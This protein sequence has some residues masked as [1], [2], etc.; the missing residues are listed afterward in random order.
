MF[1]RVWSRSA[2]RCWADVGLGGRQAFPRAPGS[3]RYNHTRWFQWHADTGSAATQADLTCRNA[4]AV[5]YLSMYPYR[6][7]G[8]CLV[9]TLRHM[10]T[11]PICIVSRSALAR[12]TSAAER[13]TLSSAWY[14]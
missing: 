12:L 14:R 8:F 4:T 2:R 13:L 10:S 9:Q 3:Y 6:H 7:L 5:R 11:Q 1:E